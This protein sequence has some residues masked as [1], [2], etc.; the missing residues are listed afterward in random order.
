MAAGITMPK[1]NLK[2]LEKRL[3]AN[4]GLTPED[5]TPKLY[6]DADMPFSYVTPKLIRELELLEPFG[7]MNEKPVFARKDVIFTGGRIVGKNHDV[8]IFNIREEGSSDTFKLKLFRNLA[9]F[10]TYLD[11]T[12]GEGTAA[13]LYRGK[14]I[15]LKVAYYP[16]LNEFRGETSV[17]FILTDFA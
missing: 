1:E 15:R 6:I 5:L 9:E 11:E 12:F 8:G 17:E 16:E 2:E 13:D 7:A 3:H 10:H 14:N 4:A